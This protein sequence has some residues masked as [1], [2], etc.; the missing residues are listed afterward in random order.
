MVKSNTK[1]LF[2]ILSLGIVGFYNQST[3]CS[4]YNIRDDEG[5][6]EDEMLLDD[7]LHSRSDGSI[8]IRSLNF[9]EKRSLS[10]APEVSDRQQKVWNTIDT[11]D[12]YKV[13]NLYTRY[14]IMLY[15]VVLCCIMLYVCYIY[16]FF[17]G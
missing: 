11:M 10:I 2:K 5:R 6:G 1:T 16:L 13:G 14:V 12:S 17:L 7:L 8:T 4:A 15:C 3:S 9:D